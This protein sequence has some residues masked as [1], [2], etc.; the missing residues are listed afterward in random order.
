MDEAEGAVSGE[1]AEAGVIGPTAAV[2]PPEP[3][4][5]L[6]S[7]ALRKAMDDKGLSQTAL[8]K[9]AEISQAA[10]SNALNVRRS[11]PSTETVSA[12]AT[13]LGITGADLVAFR[14]YRARAAEPTISGPPSEPAVE[15]YPEG[16]DNGGF[17]ASGSRPAADP[18]HHAG[19]PAHPL[20]SP[21]LRRYLDA[22]IRSS[23]VHPY[24]GVLPGVD[25]PPLSVVYLR[26]RARAQML[27]DGVPAWARGLWTPTPS[28]AGTAPA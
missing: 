1:E 9:A 17:A 16:E 18:S 22:V 3:P 14:H 4:R 21:D 26:Q 2:V 12:L 10:V 15:A 13:V 27:A 8:A 19:H 6:L 25:P 5:L 11:T 20:C 28:L 7:R 24:P 23:D